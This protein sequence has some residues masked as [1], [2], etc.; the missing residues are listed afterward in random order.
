MNG[1]GIMKKCEGE[2]VDQ[3]HKLGRLSV[4]GMNSGPCRGLDGA[5]IATKGVNNSRISG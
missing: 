5:E 3:R 4:F 1:L 2:C